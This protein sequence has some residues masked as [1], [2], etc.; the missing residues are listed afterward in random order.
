MKVPKSSGAEDRNI[1]SQFKLT[2][3]DRILLHLL[4]Y[5]QSKNKREAPFSI[6]QKGIAEGV[7]IRWNHVPRAMGKLKKLGFISEE[8]S[9]I[10]EKTR[11]QKAYFLTDEGM[12]HARNLRERI[13][14]WN[15][16][17]KKTDG[18]VINCKL[19]EIN[20]KLKTNLSPLS[21]Y[22][23]I[24]DEGEILEKNLESHQDKEKKETASK[25]F[26]VKGEITWIDDLIGRDSEIKT[27]S[28]WINS[29][30][31]STV[32]IYGSVG[33]GKSVLL[34]D[35]I[36][37]FRDKK[38]IF[39][40][41]MSESDSQIDIL[42]SLSEF[43]LELKNQTLSAYVKDHDKIDLAEVLR[44][45]DKG[46]SDSDTILT[47]DNYFSVSEEV[48]D[49]FSGLCVMAS[50]YR[51]IKLL[52]GARDTTPFYCRFYDKNDVKKKKIAELTLKGL[53][54]EGIMHLL[55]APNIE[56]DSL[57]K[58]H[59]MTRGH[60]LTIELI[61][62]GDVNSLKRIKGFS[63]QEASLLLYLKGVES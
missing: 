11:R 24:S 32:V 40:Y 29:P 6:T 44:I 31:I 2:I 61:K 49:F 38:N 34:A 47:F 58:I 53:D 5:L 59:L 22:M 60:P 21:L 10:E 30:T 52:M 14:R 43:L 33:I 42:N 4:N 27:L 55:D 16:R 23:N 48:A 35:I 56:K 1:K 25:T 46:L 57:R 36:K 54:E 20:S 9:H 62:K 8:M 13:L 12:L 18:Q 19:S 63:R 3:N 37:R 41:K 15:I 28:D 26:Y 17:L 39:W 45:L 7:G 50:R 51:N